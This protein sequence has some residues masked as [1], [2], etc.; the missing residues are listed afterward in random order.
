MSEKKEIQYQEMLDDQESINEA[1]KVGAAVAT[2]GIYLGSAIFTGLT[3][4]KAIVGDVDDAIVS[5]T[6]A[7][8]LAGLGKL[9]HVVYKNID[10]FNDLEDQE[11]L[12]DNDDLDYLDDVY[13]MDDW[14]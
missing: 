1:N 12:E 14:E 11:R 7:L 4:Y 9:S 8:S 10:V 13:F 3:I 2:A 6:I 5:G